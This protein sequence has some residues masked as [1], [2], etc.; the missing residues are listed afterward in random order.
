[1]GCQ[2]IHHR[3]RALLRAH[4]ERQSTLVLQRGAKLVTLPQ[5]G[6][7]GGLARKD[8]GTANRQGDEG[9]D[10]RRTRD[11]VYRCDLRSCFCASGLRGCS[12][13]IRLCI[14]CN[15][16]GNLRRWRGCAFRNDRSGID[17]H[18]T[19]RTN[20]RRWE[21]D[22]S[23]FD[24]LSPCL[25][26]FYCWLL[27]DGPFRYRTPAD[28]YLQRARTRVAVRHKDQAKELAFE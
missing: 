21:R 7:A 23:C 22:G 9:R 3:H 20:M 17:R 26:Q 18:K 14:R 12:I 13:H 19:P 27:V 28:V 24:H 16:D 11:T 4:R 25:S 2:E 5:L 15:D 8:A 1:M 6:Q 10:S